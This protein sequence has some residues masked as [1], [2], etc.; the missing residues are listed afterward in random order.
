MIKDLRRIF[1]QGDE[2]YRRREPSSGPFKRAGIF[3]SVE[4]RVLPSLSDKFPLQEA[5][6]G[7]SCHKNGLSDKS[8]FQDALHDKKTF[9][10]PEGSI[11]TYNIILLGETRS[12]RSAFIQGAK[13]YVDPQCKVDVDTAGSSTTSHSEDVEVHTVTTDF[14][15]YEVVYRTRSIFNRLGGSPKEYHVDINKLL[16]QETLSGYQQEISRVDGLTLRKGETSVSPRIPIR[17]FSTPDQRF[18]SVASTCKK[19]DL[20]LIMISKHTSLTTELR[21][22]LK[23]YSD[24]LLDSEEVVAFLHTDF[25]YKE[26]HAGHSAAA[27]FMKDREAMLS[28]TMMQN[29]PHFYIDCKVEEQ[30]PIYQFLTH[31]TI[32]SILLLASMNDPVSWSQTRE[33]GDSEPT[34]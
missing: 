4:T 18:A 17:I 22:T 30:R 28:K 32:R 14:A 23:R 33:N 11:H 1:Y 8:A 21:T 26:H 20:V 27:E 29:T 7:A 5:P 3:K 2:L 19:I 12:S 31:Q 16:G 9:Y 34:Q 13:R 10:D 15:E 25:D 6:C 24:N